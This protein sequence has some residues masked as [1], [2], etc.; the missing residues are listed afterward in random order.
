MVKRKAIIS[1][2]L[3]LTFSVLAL[4][5]CGTSTSGASDTLIFAQGSDPRGLDPALVDDGES[6]KIIVNIYE[7]LL[8]YD[9][10]STALKPC[11]AESWDVSPDGLT[12]TFH[13][14]KGVK[15]HDGTDFNAEAVKVNIERQMKGNATAD[16]SYA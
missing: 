5:G 14:R 13:L 12:Y 3:V 10:S 2:L 4:S 8:Q 9:K 15:F 11:L 7:G 16:M 1:L 6:S